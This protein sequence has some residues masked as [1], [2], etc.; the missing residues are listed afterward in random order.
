MVLVAVPAPESGIGPARRLHI[1]GTM[2]RGA[3]LICSALLIALTPGLAAQPET[4]G[5]AITDVGQHAVLQRFF[6]LPQTSPEELTAVRRLEARNDHFDMDAW[7]D[8]RTRA[9]ATGFRYEVLGEGGSPYIRTNVFR[10]TLQAEQKM[11]RD[12]DPDRAAFTPDNY[13]FDDR[14][15]EESGLVWLGVTPRRKDLLLVN[16]SIFL[17]PEDG[18][19]VRI[20]GALAKNPSFWTRQVEVVRRYERIAGVRVP[21]W[22][23]STASIRIA[24]KSTL[25]TTYQYLSINGQPVSQ[26]Q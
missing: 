1:S 22:M 18:D 19:L 10:P 23:Q 14:G 15:S 12:G 26:D 17:R 3:C 21:V 4:N 2:L 9:D 8:V 7:M 24:G 13:H 5:K 16:G 6:A 20:E 25:T 11:W